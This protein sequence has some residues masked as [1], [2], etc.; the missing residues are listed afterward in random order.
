MEPLLYLVHR[1]PF[2][3][4]KGDKI[5]SYHLLRHLSERYAVHLG[6]FVDNPGDRVHIP[7]LAGLCASHHVEALDPRAARVRS[8]CALLTGEALTVPYYRNAA[9]GEWVRYVVRQFGIRKA[10]VFSGAMAQYVRDLDLHVVLDFVDVDSA[11]WAAYSER[12]S[13]ISSYIFRRDFVTRAEADLFTRLAPECAGKVAVIEMGVNSD[14]FCPHPLRV[15]PFRAG[16][17]PIVFVGAMDY[18]PNIDAAVWFG[19]EVMPLLLAARPDARFYVVGMNPSAAVKALGA[20]EGVVVTGTVPDVRP[21]LQH[22]GVVVAPLRVARGV[23]SK[24]L[25]AMAMA[26]PVIVSAIVS[27]SLRGAAGREFE[28]ATTVEDFKLKVLWALE[29]AGAADLGRAARERI[30]ADYSWERNLAEFDRLLAADSAPRAQS[31]A[32]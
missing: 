12:K 17:T 26:R 7:Q 31:A 28:V 15:S 25:E 6:T 24:V 4:N 16:E 9:L 27:P 29:D 21:Y 10:I 11:K 30:L 8:A 23:Q 19:R 20:R 32:H 18:W 22:A 13:W 3:P 14:Y 2:P 1:I 5:R